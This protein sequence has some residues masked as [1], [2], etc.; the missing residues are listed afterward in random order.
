MLVFSALIAGSFSLGSLVANEVAPSA[1]NAVR[2]CLAAI[3]IG[4]VAAFGGGT[5]REHFRAPWR[6]L[7]LGTLFIGY[8]VMMFEA[9]KTASPV[10]TSA[11]LTLAPLMAAGFGYLLLRQLTTP[12]MAV[13]LLV[14][15]AG[16]IWVIFRADLA[17]LIAFEIGYGE[18]VFFGA[19]VCHALYT[20]MVRRLYRGEPMAAFS[21]GTILAGL[22]LLCILGFR[23]MLATDWLSL[24]PIVWIAILYLAV[25]AS[26]VSFLLLQFSSLRLPSAKVMAYTYLTPSFVIVWE[27]ALGHP[28]SEIRILP[29]I[30]AT[31]IALL[32]LLKDEEAAGTAS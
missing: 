27:F 4:A 29:G 17:A 25:F 11:V 26:A 10:S 5:R 12:R 3:I 24:P 13:A 20:P 9:L 7:V 30:A 21:L 8:F 1:L 28:A 15:A 32:I 14:A 22:I 6:F 16:A 18:M 31:V 19:A 2:F 23:E